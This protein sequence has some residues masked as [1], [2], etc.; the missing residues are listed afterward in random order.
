M[1]VN[2][3]KDSIHAT[4]AHI[5]VFAGITAEELRKLIPKLPSFDG[6]ANRFL[7][8]LIERSNRFASGGKPV[9]DYLSSELEEL[10]TCAQNAR[11]VTDLCGRKTRKPFLDLRGAGIA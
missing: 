3:R 6:F 7:W 4:R 10:R 1:D 11:K 5:S 2:T 9:S 8:V